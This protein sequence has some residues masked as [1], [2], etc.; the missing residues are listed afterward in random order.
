MH[1]PMYLSQTSRLIVNGIVCFLYLLDLMGGVGSSITVLISSAF[2]HILCY[3]N[4]SSQIRFFLF[5]LNNNDNSIIYT[6]R[7]FFYISNL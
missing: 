7:H 2:T 5:M 4:I 1:S 6:F 3:I